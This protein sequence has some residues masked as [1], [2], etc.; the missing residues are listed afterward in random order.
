MSKQS[1]YGGLLLGIEIY[2]IIFFILFMGYYAKRIYKLDRLAS[3]NIL[4]NNKTM[5][6][7]ITLLVILILLSIIHIVLSFADTSYWLYLYSTYS[8]V[9]CLCIVDF[10][11][12]IYIITREHKKKS[13][14]T[15][16]LILF[17]GMMMVSHIATIVIVQ[18]I[19]PNPGIAI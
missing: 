17:W 2:E 9:E 15:R 8:L 3:N 11:L 4:E 5:K 6:F 10:F 16:S 18:Y 14:S 19:N 1:T 12:Q 13:H 7:R